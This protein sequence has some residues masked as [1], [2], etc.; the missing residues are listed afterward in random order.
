MG[1]PIEARIIIK[2]LLNAN[3]LDP[4][5]DRPGINPQQF[6]DE[7]DELNFSR[8]QTFPKGYITTRAPV[9]NMDG[10][11][12]TGHNERMITIEIWYFVKS[13]IK[14]NDGVRDYK[15][16][17]YAAYMTNLIGQFL[18]RNRNLGS[19]YHI[20]NF[21]VTDGVTSSVEGAMK[22]YYDFISI[23]VHWDEI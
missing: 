2:D 14:Y 7:A 15:E 1:S 17:D 6:Y 20:K 16:K 4:H 13:D 10:F 11:G 8:G 18:Q 3:I 23:N 21:N 22:V 19:D 12:N 9:T 5:L